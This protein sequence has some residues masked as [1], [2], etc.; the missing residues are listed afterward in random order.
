MT[1]AAPALLHAL[2]DLLRGRGVDRLPTEAAVAALGERLGG[3]I[4]ATRLARTLKPYGVAPRQYRVSGSGRRVW[5][6]CLHDLPA[7]SVESRDTAPPDESRDTPKGPAAA[8][9]AAVTAPESGRGPAAQP[10]R[11]PEQ[12]WVMW[13]AMTAAY[14]R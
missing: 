5:G 3:P 14:Q 10:P 13:L 9:L 7:D 4:T 2:H 11:D 6:Y 12:E 8:P 1:A